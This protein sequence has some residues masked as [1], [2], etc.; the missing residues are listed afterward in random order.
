MH[1]HVDC[2]SGGVN[3]SWSPHGNAEGYVAVITDAD[4]HAT[5]HNTAEATLSVAAKECGREYA[6]TVTSFNGSCASFPSELKF[7]EG[8]GS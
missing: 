6:V 4:G 7:R 8:E 3:I 5:H 1:A 2:I